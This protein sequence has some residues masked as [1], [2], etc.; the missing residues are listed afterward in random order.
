MTRAPPLAGECP[1]CATVGPMPREVALRYG[2][3]HRCAACGSGVLL[4][5]PDAR[6]LLALHSSDSYLAHPYFEA[7]RSAA[8]SLRATFDARLRSLERRLGRLAGKR[9]LDIGCDTGL[10]VEHAERAAGM[11]AVGIDIFDRVVERGRAAGLELRCGTVEEAGFGDGEFDAVCAYDVV[12]HVETPGRW[13]ETVARIL[14]P[15][16][17]LV[18][19]TPNFAGAVYVAGRLL[20]RLARGE[21]PLR[22]V[23]ERLWPPFHVQYFTAASL[24]A[25]FGR[26]GFVEIDIGGREL[27][28]GETAV[29]GA[30]RPVVLGAFAAAAAVGRHTLLTAAAAKAAR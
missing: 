15:G 22:P 3:I 26:S 21:G 5:R 6:A 24:A 18:V 7:R 30:L 17:T 27:A 9:M 14:R 16:G 19:E 2:A 1:V 10:F 4:P 8:P 13:I 28:P 23:V 11:R 20:G 29:G 25:L 12:E